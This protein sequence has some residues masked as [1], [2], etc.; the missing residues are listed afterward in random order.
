VRSLDGLILIILIIRITLGFPSGLNRMREAPE[1]NHVDDPDG[2]FRQQIKPAAHRDDNQRDNKGLRK[3]MAKPGHP[4]L[5]TLP[6][7]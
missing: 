2:S 5:H 1:L 7:R 6:Q 3:H 4:R